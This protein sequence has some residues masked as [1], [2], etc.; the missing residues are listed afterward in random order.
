[1]VERALY[2]AALLLGALAVA[3]AGWLFIIDDALAFTVTSVIGVVF[4]VGVVELINF[5]RATST[6]GRALNATQDKIDDFTAWLDRLDPSLRNAVRMR[7]EGERVGLPAPVL[8]PYLVGLL[9]MLGLVGT[10]V[11]M[12]DTLR[13]AVAALEG[14]TELQAIRH[15]LAAPINGLGMAFGT[16]VAG[17]ATSAMLGLMSTLSR[18]RRMLTTRR[19]DACIPACFQD[20]SL[21]HSQR[22][23]FQALQRQTQSLPMVA[24]ML[25]RVADKLDHRS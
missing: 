23:A 12:A 10:F 18:R 3:W 21:A 4:V 8:T 1:M 24:G 2:G 25:E 14:T 6:L 20:F 5:E 9:V 15:G 17:V 22:E 11:G 7:V 16:S 13:G 19:L